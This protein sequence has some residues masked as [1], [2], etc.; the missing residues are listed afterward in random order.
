MSDRFEGMVA[1]VTG[2]AGGIGRAACV[3]FAEDG[4][5]VVAVDLAGSDLDE[6]VAAVVN[7][8]SE[9]IAV[10]ADVTR[11]ADVANYV[12]RAKFHYGRIDTFFNNAAEAVPGFVLTEDS[13]QIDEGI[14]YRDGD[15]C[16]DGSTGRLALTINGEERDDFM[17]YLPQDG[18][19]ISVRFR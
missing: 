10:E 5:K 19:E 9:C 2:A 18:D 16:P 3:R 17:S 6:T 1:I 7:A 12:E 11:E 13:L 15:P 4:A 14:E 8:G